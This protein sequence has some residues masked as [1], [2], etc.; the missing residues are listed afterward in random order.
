MVIGPTVGT[1]ERRSPGPCPAERPS[2][3]LAE[4]AGAFDHAV[5]ALDR[6]DGD[7]VAVTH[8]NRLPDVEPERLGKQPLREAD[9]GA[10]LLRRLATGHHARLG[11]RV[12]DRCCGI[13]EQ[14]S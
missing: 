2:D 14:D 13:Q 7:D 1:S 3:G 10:L 11:E 8:G 5:G 12:R 6:L 9:V 4:L